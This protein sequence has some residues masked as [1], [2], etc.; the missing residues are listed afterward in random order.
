MTGELALRV[1]V[2]AL[3]AAAV[4]W[5]L[6][7]LRLAVGRRVWRRLMRLRSTPPDRR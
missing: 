3:M 5:L 2:F 4:V 7:V 6:E 1:Y